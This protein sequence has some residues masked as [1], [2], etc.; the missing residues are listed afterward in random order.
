MPAHFKIEQLF[1]LDT[2]QIRKKKERRIAR[3]ETRSLF[4]ESQNRQTYRNEYDRLDGE[5]GNLSEIK[6]KHGDRVANLTALAIR[7][8]QGR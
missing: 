4:L 8:R 5:F 6:R 1:D 7:H 2:D 3:M